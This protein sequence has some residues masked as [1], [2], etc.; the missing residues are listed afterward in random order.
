MHV[1]CIERLMEWGFLSLEM[2][3]VKEALIGCPQLPKRWR[4][5]RDA[6]WKDKR[7][8]MK[9]ETLAIPTRPQELRFIVIKHWKMLAH[10]GSSLRDYLKH[11]L[12][13]SPQTTGLDGGTA[14]VWTIWLPQFLPIWIVW[15]FSYHPQQNN[16]TNQ[17]Q[18]TNWNWISVLNALENSAAFSRPNETKQYNRT[19]LLLILRITDPL[20][21]Q[22]G[23]L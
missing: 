15:W 11:W 16:R 13:I 2:A 23:S 14:R 6:Q 1:T 18:R 22:T 10:R 4:E 21:I 9:A 5:D 12:G 3:D 20:C 19:K 17:Q 7:Q 8:W